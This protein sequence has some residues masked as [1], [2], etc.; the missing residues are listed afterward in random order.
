MPK[1]PPDGGPFPRDARL[2]AA[3]SAL[4][5]VDAVRARDRVGVGLAGHRLRSDERP[6]HSAKG[7]H[8]TRSGG[9]GE[10]R[11]PRPY[12]QFGR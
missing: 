2:V 12:D 1:G 9:R 10:R 5:A 11:S 3:A 7:D 8:A 6:R 4:V